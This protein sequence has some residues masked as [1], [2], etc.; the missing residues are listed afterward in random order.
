VHT[1]AP[2]GGPRSFVLDVLLHSHPRARVWKEERHGRLPGPV[3]RPFYRAIAKVML[4]RSRR[5][6]RRAA[7]TDGSNS[8]TRD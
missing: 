1:A 5:S 6:S 8:T 4:R 3:V 2:G 7:Q